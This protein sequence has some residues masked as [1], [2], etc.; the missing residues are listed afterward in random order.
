MS[1]GAWGRGRTGEP[2][3]FQTGASTDCAT[4]ARFGLDGYATLLTSPGKE[5]LSV[6]HYDEIQRED[7]LDVPQEYRA[8][9]EAGIFSYFGE[10]SYEDLTEKQRLE[11]MRDRALSG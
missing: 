2:P 1:S 4:Q 6:D 11:V 10:N 7:G 5:L 8:M 3:A 9:C